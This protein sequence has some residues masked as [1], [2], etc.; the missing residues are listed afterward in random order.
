[1]LGRLFSEP[2]LW[3]GLVM[4]ELDGGLVSLFD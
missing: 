2:T 3:F 4:W 1:M